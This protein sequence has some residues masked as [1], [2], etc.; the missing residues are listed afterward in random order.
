MEPGIQYDGLRVC[1]PR[2]TSSDKVPSLV[3]GCRLGGIWK[4][5]EDGQHYHGRL[6]SAIGNRCIPR[7]HVGEICVLQL[8]FMHSTGHGSAVGVPH[9]EV[10]S[11]RARLPSFERRSGALSS[12]HAESGCGMHLIQAFFQKRTTHTANENEIFPGRR[13]VGHSCCFAILVT[14]GVRAL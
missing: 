10:G 3:T 2:N 14:P 5:A 13:L 9:Q 1:K 12:G 8:R 4:S 11:T 7:M 6:Y